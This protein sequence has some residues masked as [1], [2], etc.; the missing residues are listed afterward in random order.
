MQG[1]CC[2]PF[3]TTNGAKPGPGAQQCG[4][5]M[6]SEV[7]AAIGSGGSSV[8]T[9]DN[10]TQSDIAYFTGMGEDG[11][12]TPGTWITYNSQRSALAIAKY[13]KSKNLGSVF[14]FDSSMDTMSGNDFTY[15][16]S[17]AVAQE[18]SV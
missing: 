14:V 6:Y 8:T 10:E 17:L 1:S 2:G 3:A 5:L 11:S 7:L 15:E 9:F 12:A 18:L 13:A 16:L 4:T